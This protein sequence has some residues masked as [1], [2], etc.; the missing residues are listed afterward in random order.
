MLIT[1]RYVNYLTTVHRV[2]ITA[3]ISHLNYCHK[4]NVLKKKIMNWNLSI[5]LKSRIV[6]GIV[7]NRKIWYK[8]NWKILNLTAIE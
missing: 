6:A 5:Q 4:D 3:Y 8:I 7:W 1:V 2:H